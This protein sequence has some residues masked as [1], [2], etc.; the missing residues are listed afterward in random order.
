MLRT[1]TIHTMI[2][3]TVAVMLSAL[4]LCGCGDKITTISTVEELPKEDGIDKSYEQTDAGNYMVVPIMYQ[5]SYGDV[6]LGDATVAE[7]GAAVTTLC[8]ALSYATS[9]LI[10]P[11]DFI[12]KY[13]PYINNSGVVD[14]GKALADTKGLRYEAKIFD[15]QDMAEHL[16]EDNTTICIVEIN[17][18]SPYSEGLTYLILTGCTEE[19]YMCVRDP[20][21]DNKE[22]YEISSTYYGESLYS[23]A[24]VLA[25]LGTNAKAYYI[26]YGVSK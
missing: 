3:K 26:Y 17:H 19:G 13:E 18:N 8:M 14:I 21:L 9:S 22:K 11:A 24:D 1:S 20:N 4:L 15:F 10:E 7:R 2:K 5:Q 25:A 23:T 12:S 16:W 6:V